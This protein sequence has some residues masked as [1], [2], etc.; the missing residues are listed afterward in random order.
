M[1]LDLGPHRP[2]YGISVAAEITGVNAPMLRA[3]ESKGLIQPFRT[4][5]GTRRY[6]ETDLASVNR[7]TTLLA[8]G[9]NLAGVQ[10][11]LRL[12]DET[13]ELRAEVKGLQERLD[14][15]PRKNT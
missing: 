14:R 8:A 7:I 12:E 6:S 9:L 2:L 1:E 13:R 15:Q 10:E 5:G 4:D 11:V 3:Y